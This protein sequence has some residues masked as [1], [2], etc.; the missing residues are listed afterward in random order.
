MEPGIEAI[1][2]IRPAA[3]YVA[4]AV[5]TVILL[6]FVA[7]RGL[8]KPLPISHARS[9]MG[10][11]DIEAFRNLVDPQQEIF[12][13]ASL[14]AKEFLKIKRERVWA[15]VAYTRALSYIA[16]QFSRFGN[17]ARRAD[18]ASLAELGK[19]MAV[20][21]VELR[22]SSLA[23][24]GR[25]LIIAT[26][27]NLSF[28]SSHSLIEQHLRSTGLLARYITLESARR[29]VPSVAQVA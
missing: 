5:V 19:Q 24:M 26:F 8:G 17:A 12:L 14:P 29:Q 28:P 16:L 10:S 25:L 6:T 13:R 11:L 15:A 23:T 9:L 20:D 4:F 7:I 22:M 1:F 27:P 3:I 21:A 18:D 2:A